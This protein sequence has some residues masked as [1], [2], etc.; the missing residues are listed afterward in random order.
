MKVDAMKN[1]AIH[2][3]TI[4]V[5]ACHKNQNKILQLKSTP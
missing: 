4:S 3:D 1:N 5:T 2:Q